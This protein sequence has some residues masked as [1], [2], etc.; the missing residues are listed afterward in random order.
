MRL[1]SLIQ[2]LLSL[3]PV[4]IAVGV[5]SLIASAFSLKLSPL[6]AVS[7]PLV[8]AV[9]TEFTSLILLRFVE[10]RGRGLGPREA[11]DGTASRT[12]RPSWCR[13]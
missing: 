2:S 12:G 1:R 7:G 9:C 8:V 10:E 5:V 6:T 13:G 4:L 11:A 3:I